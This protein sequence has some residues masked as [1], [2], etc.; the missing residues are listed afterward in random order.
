MKRRESGIDS[1]SV[2]HFHLFT[3]LPFQRFRGHV[4]VVIFRHFVSYGMV[5]QV[6]AVERIG[7]RFERL[8]THGGLQLTLPYGDSVPP[9]A[10]QSQLLVLVADA[11]TLYF[12]APEVRIGLW[13]MESRAVMP[14]PEAAVY[15]YA[16]A[17]FA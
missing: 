7:E 8:F 10:R 9:H 3:F 4:P 14:V 5:L 16:S 11:V 1:Y 6:N 12:G 2:S 15:E 13:K 17:V